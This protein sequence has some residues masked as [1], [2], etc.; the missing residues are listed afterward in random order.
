M[1]KTMANFEKAWNEYWQTG[2]STSCVSNG[3]DGYPPAIKNYWNKVAFKNLKNQDEVVDLC[4]GGGGV[5]KLMIDYCHDKEIGLNI[6]ITD[7]ATITKNIKSD[8]SIK[9]K[10][11][12]ECN[13]EKLPFKDNSC[14]FISSSYGVEYSNLKQTMTEINRTLSTDGVFCSVIHCDDSA[15]VKNSNGQLEQGNEILYKLNFF[16]LFRDIYLARTK[17][18]VLQKSKEKK[19]LKCLDEIKLRLLHDNELHVYRS[20]LKAAHDIFVFGQTNKPIKCIE[21]I[22]K[23]EKSLK[24][25]Y[26]RME[27]LAEVVLTNND[28]SELIDHIESLGLKVIFN[29][30]IKSDKNKI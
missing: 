13:C 23:M 18:A 4:S 17:S 9:I 3:K 20:I 24:Y 1:S 21:Y 26:Q 8:A 16:D 30:K 25:N 14:D 22:N 10:Y 7:L 2:L 6:S 28:I 15:I 5:P 27:N 12:S 19:L 11:F 29:E